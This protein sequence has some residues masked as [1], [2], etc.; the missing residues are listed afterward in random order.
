MHTPIA[1]RAYVDAISRGSARP[2]KFGA[3]NPASH[4][5]LQNEQRSKR[6]QL[7]NTQWP[8]L[9][10]KCRIFSEIIQLHLSCGYCKQLQPYVF[11]ANHNFPI[12]LQ[13][14]A[15]IS[16]LLQIFP[17]NCNYCNLCTPIELITNFKSDRLLILI[18]RTAVQAIASI[19]IQVHIFWAICFPPTSHCT[20]FNATAILS[21]VMHAYVSRKL[22]YFNTTAP[23]SIQLRS[24]Q[25][26]WSNILNQ[27]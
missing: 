2:I 12:Y 25:P 11:G 3:D 20:Y 26:I 13:A 1:P 5:T 15:S 24:F 22:Q 27:Q 7:L 9:I 18:V 8:I 14:T 10:N 21:I 19:L 4:P 6:N 17:A 23:I 16:V